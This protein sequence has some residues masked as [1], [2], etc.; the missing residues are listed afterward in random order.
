MTEKKYIQFFF[1]TKHSNELNYAVPNKIDKFRPISQAFSE[2]MK[3]ETTI[4]RA[5][6]LNGK[7]QK[8]K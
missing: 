7:S 2:K 3:S 1:T 8:S 4:K 6:R 5:A